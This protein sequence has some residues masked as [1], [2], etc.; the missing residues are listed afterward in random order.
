MLAGREQG[1][2]TG[3]TNRNERETIMK[4]RFTLNMYR[5]DMGSFRQPGCR[6]AEDALWHINKAREHD[7]L[8]PI[9]LDDLY[10]ALDSRAPASFRAK[11]SPE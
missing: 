9:E 2:A 4:T 7:G 6:D 1:R 5:D 10:E 8:P 3:E 11:L